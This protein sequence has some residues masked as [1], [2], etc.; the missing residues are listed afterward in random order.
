MIIFLSFMSTLPMNIFHFMYQ[1]YSNF[2]GVLF[3]D[4]QY[5][6]FMIFSTI[7]MVYAGIILFP[8]QKFV[9]F[10]FTEVYNESELFYKHFGRVIG[11]ASF[12]TFIECFYVL[13]TMQKFMTHTFMLDNHGY[14]TS[15][16]IVGATYLV[17]SM[18]IFV[19]RVYFLTKNGGSSILTLGFSMIFL[20]LV[21][22][23][24]SDLWFTSS[25]D[26]NFLTIV[27]Q[28][29][30]YW[31]VFMQV[32]LIPLLAEYVFISG[33]RS[34]LIYPAYRMIVKHYR[35]RDLNFFSTSGKDK[36]AR[37]LRTKIEFS[38][39]SIVKFVYKGIKILDI[40]DDVKK[41]LSMD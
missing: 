21:G 13:Y 34:N 6:T 11:I 40:D 4:F 27:V 14:T 8:Y 30:N 10:K 16:D 37:L 31:F 39:S 22:T 17:S 5:F 28:E 35:A 36:L 24:I 20:Y 32:T 33:I 18:I 23:M 2:A 26:E 3:K 29:P 19:G 12:L 25:L 38:L 9:L 7:L 15:E 41:I 1:I